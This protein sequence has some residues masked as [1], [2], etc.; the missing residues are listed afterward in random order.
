MSSRA[1]LGGQFSQL[2]SLRRSERRRMAGDMLDSPDNNA[3]TECALW[4]RA[5]Y[6]CE[7]KKAYFSEKREMLSQGN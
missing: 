3:L 1:S 5:F 7:W 2:T 4:K 6:T